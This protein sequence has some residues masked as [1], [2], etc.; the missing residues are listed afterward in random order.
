MFRFCEEVQQFISACEGVQ[1]LLM[2]SEALTTDEK[3][4]VELSARELLASL[5]FDRVKL[6][7]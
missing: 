1:F 3:S 4:V 6:S 7:S 5:A 2:Q